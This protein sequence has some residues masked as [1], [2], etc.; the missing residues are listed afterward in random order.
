MNLESRKLP[1]LLVD[2]EEGVIDL[3]WG[4]PSPFLHPLEDIEFASRSLFASN[5]SLSLIHI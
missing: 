5:D 2:I 1:S 3:G 4:H